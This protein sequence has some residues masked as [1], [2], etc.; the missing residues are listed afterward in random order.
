[1]G[2]RPEP[3][4]ARTWLEVVMYDCYHGNRH[5][6]PSR[7]FLTVAGAGFVTNARNELVR[8]FLAQPED[9]RADWLLFL[10]DDQV[11]PEYLLEILMGSAHPVERRIVA[12]PVWRFISNDGGPIRVTHNVFDV[13]EGGGI[14]EWTEPFPENA[15][16]QVPAVGTGCMLIH[17]TVLEE[18]QQVAIENG[19]GAKWCWFAQQTYLP[20][21]VCEGEDIW[22]CRLAAATGIP[23]WI[24][25]SMTLQHAKTIMLQGPAPAG[26]LSI[27]GEPGWFYTE[28]VTPAATE[29]VD[30]IV[31]VLHRPQN[32]KPLMDSLKATAPL[33]TA[34]FVC[35][36]DDLIQWAEVEKHG[37]KRLVYPGTF[38]QK[39]NYAYTQTSAPWLMLV[40]DDVVFRN[41]WLDEAQAVAAKTGGNVIGTNDLGNARVMAGEH[42]THMMIRRSYIDEVG[43]SWDGPGVVCHEGY[44]HWFV[45]DELICAAKQRKTFHPALR[46]IVEHMHPIWGKAKNDDVYAKG[47]EG[48]AKDKETFNRRFRKS[49]AAV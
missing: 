30:V 7:P 5:I 38:A 21:D 16:I 42:A 35:E 18:M 3:H 29:P 34:W 4:T 26:S 43:A 11:Y 17:R 22:F 47:Q 28:E 15:V 20:A 8:K 2:D 36:P 41:G 48:V 31:P 49:L 10:D 40:G 44:S 33:A 46:S 27:G 6:H 23:V 13:D 12:M 19:R 37:G 45:D 9:D 39:V 14:I 32:V 1:M 25:T 24:N